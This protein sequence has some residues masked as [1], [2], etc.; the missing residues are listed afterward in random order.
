M[1]GIAGHD[2]YLRV[3]RDFNERE[4]AGIR[5][6]A[7]DREGR[8]EYALPLDKH[9]DFLDSIFRESELLPPQH[10]GILIEDPCVEHEDHA[11]IDNE[12]EDAGRSPAA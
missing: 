5:D 10:I 9:E 1:P 11:A 7:R 4:I 6:R 2:G 8:D 3:E 12:V